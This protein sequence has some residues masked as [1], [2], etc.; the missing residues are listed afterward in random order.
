M[1]LQKL[2][3]DQYARGQDRW[4]DAERAFQE[5][6]WPDTLRYSQEAVE[7]V[8]KALLRA[9]AVEAPKRHDVGPVLE[10]VGP[11]LPS[12]LRR[13]LPAIVELSAAL[14]DRRAL[15]MY[16]DEVGGRTASEIFHSQAEA[17]EFLDRAGRL[18]RLVGKALATTRR[19]VPRT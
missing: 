9:L 14:A 16:G 1:N 17:K 11:D 13:E 12:I 15:A 10:Q 3:R 6:R 5:R 2:S 7:L 18:V 8:L 4:R 19:G